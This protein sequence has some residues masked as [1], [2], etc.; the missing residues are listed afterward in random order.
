MV[1]RRSRFLLLGDLPAGHD[2]QCVYECL[3]ELT[4]DLPAA[5]RRSLTWDQSREMAN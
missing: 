1:G 3:M 5:L 2:A 4:A